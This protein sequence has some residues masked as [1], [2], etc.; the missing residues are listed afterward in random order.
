M[1]SFLLVYI[2]EN[3]KFDRSEIIQAI[4]SIEGIYDISI[5]QENS[6]DEKKLKYVLFCEYCKE[7]EI[8]TV[9]VDVDLKSIVVKR[10][11]RASFNFALD[12][13]QKLNM[14]LTATDCD[15]SFL[16]KLDKIKSVEEFER[17][18]D[19]QIYMDEQ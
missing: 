15:Y 17:V 3:I 12:L 13:Q 4:S 1:S 5:T 6:I 8:V 14:G 11:G 10:V 2:D 19:Q 18:Y 16:C 9:R 7:T